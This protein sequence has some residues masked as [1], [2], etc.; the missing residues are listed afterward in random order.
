MN[1]LTGLREWRQM[2]RRDRDMQQFA[3]VL[4]GPIRERLAGEQADA[5][6]GQRPADPEALFQAL[7]ESARKWR[8]DRPLEV[9]RVRIPRKFGAT[10]MWVE[11]Q[12]QDDVIIEADAEVWH[13]A[14]ILGHELW[15]MRQKDGLTPEQLAAEACSPTGS[16]HPHAAQPAAARSR[17]DE[18][19]EKEAELFGILVGQQ[20]RSLMDRDVIAGDTA[21]RIA[22]SL[23]Y[24][25]NRR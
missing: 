14:Q 10:G 19:P 3:D 13:Q 22:D 9:H 6:G 2:R 16:G 17:F 1:P 24:Q 7:V 11:R 5:S 21:R 12:Q 18:D 8:G 15:H 20:M 4:I 23:G 25:R